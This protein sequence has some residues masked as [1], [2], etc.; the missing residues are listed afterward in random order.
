MNEPDYRK[1][2]QSIQEDRPEGFRVAE[3]H[4]NFESMDLD[5]QDRIR[6]RICDRLK[7]TASYYLNDELEIV[8]DSSIDDKWTYDIVHSCGQ[9]PMYDELNDEHYCPI[10][11]D[12]E[13][14]FD[15]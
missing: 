15:Y 10:C 13:S 4:V 12:K 1:V 9:T 11:K 7:E 3:I 8:T 5:I 2:A 14:V 6:D